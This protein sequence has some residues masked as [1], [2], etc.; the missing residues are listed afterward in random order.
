MGRAE[1]A[2]LLARDGEED[3]RGVE[4][5]LRHDPGQF[6]RDR[7]ARGVVVGT[8]GVDLRVGDRPGD[9]VVMPAD[10]EPSVS[11]GRLVAGQDGH[12]VDQRGRPRHAQGDRL[13][14]RILLD[15]QPAARLLR[16]GFQL[17]LDPAT[18]RAD[19]AGGV[20]GVGERVPGAEPGELPDRRLDPGGRDLGQ[21]RL[22][23]AVLPCPYEH[24]LRS[25]R[26]GYQESK[27]Q[28][29]DGCVSHRAASSGKCRFATQS[30][31]H[32]R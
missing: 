9:R 32:S 1:Q 16:V 19:A 28:R 14:E 24:L 2:L 21:D 20:V 15:D 17:G 11:R 10:D 25:G 4:V 29:G 27:G 12:Q 31:Q 7:R 30:E 8:R 18:G 26:P 13:H 5:V 23:R 3:E 6:Q 22:D